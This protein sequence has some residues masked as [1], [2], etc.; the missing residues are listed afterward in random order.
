VDGTRETL[1]RLVQ[2]VEK[3]RLD[4]APPRNHWW[5]VPFHPT[6]R[7]ITSRPVGTDVVLCFDFDFVYHRLVVSSLSGVVASFAPPGLSVVGSPR[8]VMAALE[9]LGSL[10]AF[11]PS[12]SA[13]PTAPFAD[14]HEHAW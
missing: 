5:H 4:E 3:V 1:H 9:V 8:R 6:G 7:N 12:A 11:A 10:R 14:D 2:V 13:S